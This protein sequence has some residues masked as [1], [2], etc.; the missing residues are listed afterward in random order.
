MIV[1]F[2][3]TYSLIYWGRCEI[4]CSKYRCHCGK[5]SSLLK[6]DRC[7]LFRN[8]IETN[9]INHI[10]FCLEFSF[11]EKF[12]YFYA[13]RRHFINWPVLN[14]LCST[15]AGTEVVVFLTPI[16]E[17]W[18]QISNRLRPMTLTFLAI[19][20]PSNCRSAESVVK[21]TINKW[22]NT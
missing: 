20:E 15:T 1:S 9:K 3:A 4:S 18:K 10:K 13:S 17:F 6:K 8:K 12:L 11:K 7:R 5:S 22:I 21:Q 19:S 2:D 16:S 14:P